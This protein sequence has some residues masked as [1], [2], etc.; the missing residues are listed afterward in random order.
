MGVEASEILPWLKC[1]GI[2][3][4]W[5]CRFLSAEK[6]VDLGGEAE[7]KSKLTAY[8]KQSVAE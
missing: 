1:L 8:C 4:K 6:A 5:I 7:G 2:K 3:I